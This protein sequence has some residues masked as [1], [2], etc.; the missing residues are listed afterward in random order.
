MASVSSKAHLLDLL[1]EVTCEKVVH[2]LQI[3]VYLPGSNPKINACQPI[4]FV[5]QLA[6]FE[7]GVTKTAS[8]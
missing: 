7:H 6:M 1:Q 4:A 5:K 2:W 3:G 8:M